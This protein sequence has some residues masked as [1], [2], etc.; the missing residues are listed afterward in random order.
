VKCDTHRF[1][2]QVSYRATIVLF[3]SAA[4]LRGGFFLSQSLSAQSFSDGRDS[5]SGI[6]VNSLTREPIARALARIIRECEEIGR[7]K[8]PPL[9]QTC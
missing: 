4:C 3:L 1:L 5:V 2:R 6:V 9:L 8:K 7:Q